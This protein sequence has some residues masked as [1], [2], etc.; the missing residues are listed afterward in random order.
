MIE[1][2]GSNQMNTIELSVSNPL[3]RFLRAT[4]HGFFKSENLGAYIRLSWEGRT[5]L[6]VEICPEIK[7]MEATEGRGRNRKQGYID[8]TNNPEGRKSMIKEI[9]SRLPDN[10][11]KSNFTSYSLNVEEDM[12]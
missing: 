6:K 9:I 7:I 4:R 2:Y 12:K 3:G 1:R 5:Q 11:Y 10:H 8:L